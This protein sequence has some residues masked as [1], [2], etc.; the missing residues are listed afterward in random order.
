MYSDP[1]FFLHH[2][3]VDRLWWLWQ[4]KDAGTRTNAYNGE[5]LDKKP[6]SLSN[7]MPMAGLATDRAVRDVM[8]VRGGFLCYTY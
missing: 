4:Q 1:L 7:V 2:T 3:Q 8:D 5:G 6:V